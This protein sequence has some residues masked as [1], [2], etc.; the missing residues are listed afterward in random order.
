M[1]PFVVALLLAPLA[2]SAG[3]A[4]FGA[5]LPPGTAGPSFV[6]ESEKLP[7]LSS[8]MRE[9][10]QALDDAV[11]AEVEGSFLLLEDLVRSSQALREQMRRVRERIDALASDEERP[12]GLDRDLLLEG[13][14][15]YIEL[16]LLL[17]NLWT[18]YR[19]YLPYASEPDPYAPYRGVSL[20]SRETRARGG[21]VAL[22]AEITRME[23]ARV[24]LEQLAG[25]WAIVQFLNRGDEARGIQPES[26]D[27]MVGA[28]YDPE[29]RSL[30]KAQLS[31]IRQ[32]R[33][34]FD[35]LARE[36]GQVA[37]L[38]ALLDETAV[39]K[40]L[41]EE[42]T[43]GRQFR[44]ASAVAARSG[45]AL[46][47]PFLALYIERV[48]A[49][50]AAREGPL[51]QLAAQPD[52]RDGLVDALAP[53]DLL[54]LRDE[55]RAGVGEAYTHVAL[56]LGAYETL[57]AAPVSEQAAFAPQRDRVRQGRTF[58][59][60]SQ[61]GARLVHLDDVLAAQD[62]AVLRYPMSADEEDALL[63]RAFELLADPGFVTPPQLTQREHAARLW[64]AL[65]GERAGILAE[66]DD[67][68]PPL[69]A[70][71]QAALADA[72]GA[73]VVFSTL[74]GVVMPEGERAAAIRRSLERQGPIDDVSVP[75]GR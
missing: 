37:W 68:P 42:T 31:A 35:A 73:R 41:L 67:R 74:D 16:D 62:V 18:S 12:A 66:R 59:D 9:R 44:F 57:K 51:R 64:L 3:C 32:A 13:A 25:Q 7:Q 52:V 55:T 21:L 33:P 43:F 72:V 29:R 23:N 60:V 39:A 22:A 15:W 50:A 10:R 19:R 48:L 24:V 49:E 61:R 20:L 6:E 46:L 47:S 5:N 53:G 26:F 71:V 17:Y 28:Y 4:L 58:L 65:L 11:R 54:V 56:Y 1:R 69:S 2:G 36:D 27:R 14:H 30:L 38:L 8:N 40:E 63:S 70:L 45:V 75:D 34:R